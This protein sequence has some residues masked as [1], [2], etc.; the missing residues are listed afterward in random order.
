MSIGILFESSE[1]DEKGIKMT[2][3]QMGIDLTYIPFRKV[4]VR[5]DE[6]SYSLRTKGKDYTKILKDLKV[7]L[8]RAQSKNRR[9]FAANVLEAF[10]KHVI[11]PQSVEYAC[12]SK[13]RTL[14]HFWK[15]GLPTPETVYVPV[16]S[17]E[18]TVD[19]REV[20]NEGDIADLLQMELDHENIVIK[21]DAGT[22]GKDVQLAKERDDMLAILR[23]I[24]PSIINPVGI[25][26][27]KLVQKW[28]Y[29]LRIIVTKENRKQPYCY[30]T[31]LARAGFKDFRTNTFL[32]NMVI[33]VNL[34]EHIREVSAKCGAAMGGDSKAYLLAFD[35]MIGVGE[36]RDFNDEYLMEEFDK[37]EPSF[38]AVK[39]VKLDKTKRTNFPE[40]N[41]KLEKAFENYK[42]QEAYQNLKKIIEESMEKNKN[43]VMFHEA[44]ACPEFWEQTRL[45]AGINLAE[46]LLKG[47]QSIIDSE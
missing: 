44:N 36:N 40:W 2:A 4:A 33:G 28:F 26:S 18:K 3:E 17:N 47:A 30:P 23:E 46:P 20:H 6:H 25:L 37:L 10:G 35:A 7:V 27:Q 29:D 34:P 43:N 8:N 1:T 39:N 19:G 5:L 13:L 14:L 11:N 22:H 38:G 31:A 15:A 41:R 42:N 9:L 21:P 24:Q 32:G 45:A 12:F 16:D